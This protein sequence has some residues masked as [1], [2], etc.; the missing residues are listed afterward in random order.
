MSKND[1][2]FFISQSSYFLNMLKEVY[3]PKFIIKDVLQ[4][5]HLPFV[6]DYDLIVSVICEMSGTA[7]L[8]E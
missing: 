1:K 7:E 8:D 2:S 4:S 3:S 5:L 6:S